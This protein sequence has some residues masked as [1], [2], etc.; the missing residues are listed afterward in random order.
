MPRGHVISD[1]R[2]VAALRGE[3][4]LTQWQAGQGSRLRSANDRQDRER[5]TDWR[6]HVG[7]RRNRAQSPA[8]A[9]G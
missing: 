9:A 1:G 8:E 7:R 4:D 2:K 5:A 3:A 6:G